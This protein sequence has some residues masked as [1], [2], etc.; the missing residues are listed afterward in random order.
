MMMRRAL[1]RSTSVGGHYQQRAHLHASRPALA[2]ILCADSI[3]PVRWKGREGRGG[4]EGGG[5]LF[6]CHVGQHVVQVD[7]AVEARE[8]H[9]DLRA[10][11]T[12]CVFPALFLHV[13]LRGCRA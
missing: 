10:S 2:K 5:V 4:R 6:R 12:R 11:K 3:D 7:D 9:T 1:Q 8:G 13:M